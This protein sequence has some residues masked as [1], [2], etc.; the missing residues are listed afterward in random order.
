MAI[1]NDDLEIKAQKGL[2]AL[3]RAVAKAIE[4]RDQIHNQTQAN[5]STNTARDGDCGGD[6]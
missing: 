6:R 1:Q 3:R 4:R 2:D 5:S